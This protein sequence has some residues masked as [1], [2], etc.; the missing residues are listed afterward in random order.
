MQF[1]FEKDTLSPAEI[2]ITEVK[3]CELQSDLCVEGNISRKE[4]ILVWFTHS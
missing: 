1:S 2:S 3:D 4:R